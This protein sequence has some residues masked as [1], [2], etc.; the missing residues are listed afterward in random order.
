M[1]TQKQ[2]R[3]G[4]GM[5]LNSPDFCPLGPNLAVFG[6]MD[7]GGSIGFADP[8]SKLA[9]A[10]V[11]ESFHTPNKHDKSLCGKRQQNLIKGLYKS[12]L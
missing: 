2:W 1:A 7:M 9:F 3:M 8:E 6:H 5:M 4:A 10:Y 12:I 11:T